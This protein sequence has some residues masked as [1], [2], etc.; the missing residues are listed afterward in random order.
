MDTIKLNAYAKIN[1]SLEVIGRREN[2][3]H[4]IDSVMQGVDLCDQITVIAGSSSEIEETEYCK[5][6]CKYENVD[7]YLESES[8]GMPFDESN[9]AVKGVKAVID[10]LHKQAIERDFPTSLCIRIDKNL[11]IAAGIAGGSGNAAA[12]MLGLNAILGNPLSLEDLL[13][14]GTGVGADVP[15]SISMNAARNRDTLTSLNG[16]MKASVSARTAGIGEVLTPIDP[17]K[18]S[19]IM[20]NP[21]I[22]VSTAEVYRAI[23]ALDN[24]EINTNLFYNRMEEYTLNEYP[25]AKELKEAMELN[26]NA[27]NVLMSGSGPTM[28]AYYDD[29]KLAMADYREINSWLDINAR[30]W[31]S[32]T[33]E[34]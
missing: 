6:I 28:V 12:S 7:I 20:I 32:K 5:R 8:K 21:G 17:I 1:L 11:P 31:I 18:K 13:D 9:L 29:E 14:I 25:A 26:L 33:G 22:G 34:E 30:A 27:D 10:S 2:G 4:D 23:D 15:F 3:Y 16:V 24:R 19:I